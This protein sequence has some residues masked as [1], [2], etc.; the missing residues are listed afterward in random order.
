VKFGWLAHDI[1][2]KPHWPAGTF[3]DT[4]NEVDLDC[5]LKYDGEL[6]SFS[7]SKTHHIELNTFP[8]T[9]EVSFIMVICTNKS[10]TVNKTLMCEPF[11]HNPM[12]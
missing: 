11:G 6:F 4:S 9:R 5:D 3:I 7:E 12:I 2:R 10:I 8:S 1:N